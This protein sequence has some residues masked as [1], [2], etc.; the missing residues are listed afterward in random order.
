MID[1]MEQGR[2]DGVKERVGRGIQDDSA[3]RDARFQLGSAFGVQRGRSPHGVRP[4]V[5]R[6][7]QPI[8]NV[9]FLVGEARMRLQQV[10]EN[11]FPL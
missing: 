1:V 4:F 7:R 3:L 5:Q 2:L 9:S 8:Q 11:V 6:T 10:I